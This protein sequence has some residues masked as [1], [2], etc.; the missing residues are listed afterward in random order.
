MF[1]I[2]QYFLFVYTS[3][4]F[5]EIPRRLQLVR[6]NIRNFSENIFINSIIETNQYQNILCFNS[7]YSNMIFTNNDG[8]Y[9][10]PHCL[11]L[12]N[13]IGFPQK[14]CNQT[15]FNLSIT[16]CLPLLYIYNN[17]QISIIIKKANSSENHSFKKCSTQGVSTFLEYPQN[18][19]IWT[20]KTIE[21]GDIISVVIIHKHLSGN[22]IEAISFKYIGNDQ[23]EKNNILKII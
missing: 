18:F 7:L 16:S 15:C 5:H 11:T 2:N 4:N 12:I 8:F 1:L 10:R 14:I 9:I 3:F 13:Y 21:V 6:R 20:F 23:F 17:Y 22:K 19:L